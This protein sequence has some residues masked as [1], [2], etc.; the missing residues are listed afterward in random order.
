MPNTLVGPSWYQ[1]A[2]VVPF[3]IVP[4]L[5][6]TS[7]KMD[8]WSVSAPWRPARKTQ[9]RDLIQ[10]GPGVFPVLCSSHHL[11]RI[12]RA[13]GENKA[14]LHEYREVLSVAS[15]TFTDAYIIFGVLHTSCNQDEYMRVMLTCKYQAWAQLDA[16]IKSEHLANSSPN[17]WTGNVSVAQT[18]DDGLPSENMRRYCQLALGPSSSTFPTHPEL[19][20]CV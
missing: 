7:N 11:L 2:L 16:T 18:G 3:R 14:W 10:S 12:S 1:W 6:S 15:F 4:V 13:G 5:A 20:A 19:T 9:D 8:E 17:A